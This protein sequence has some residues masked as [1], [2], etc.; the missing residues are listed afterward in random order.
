MADFHSLPFSFPLKRGN[1]KLIN[2]KGYYC[3]TH[4]YLQEL[5]AF[6]LCY[7]IHK[8]KMYKK[9][10]SEYSHI[11]TMR[12]GKNLDFCKVITIK[13]TRLQWMQNPFYSIFHEWV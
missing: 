12:Y 10:S 7:L 6:L 4:T 8:S 1:L 5:N 11:K 2:F 9:G 3:R 13:S